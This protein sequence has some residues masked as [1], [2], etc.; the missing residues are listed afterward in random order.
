MGHSRSRRTLHSGS[1]VGSLVGRERVGGSPGRGPPT[2][3]AERDRNEQ[4][5]ARMTVMAQEATRL[6]GSEES[7]LSRASGQ[8]CAL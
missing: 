6:A 4:V 1:C 5:Q 7:G 8:S 3:T 2:G